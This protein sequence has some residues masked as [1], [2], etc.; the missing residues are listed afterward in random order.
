[1]CSS[2]LA[3][4]SL[5]VFIRLLDL[6]SLFPSKPFIL[7]EHSL[8]QSYFLM[9]LLILPH[10]SWD[11]S[12]K[13]F[14]LLSSDKQ[15]NQTLLETSLKYNPCSTDNRD[16]MVLR[17]NSKHPEREE[18]GCISSHTLHSLPKEMCKLLFYSVLLHALLL[19]SLKCIV[20]NFLF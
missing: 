18:H 16:F 5:S 19:L 13:P 14:R 15:L 20:S 7:L 10:F 9:L 1:M 6:S 17:V 3:Q 4:F 8:P 12:Q 2:P 11:S